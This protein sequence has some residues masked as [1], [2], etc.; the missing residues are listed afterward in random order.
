MDEALL[1]N[2]TP[3]VLGILMQPVL[4]E[5]LRVWR[6][7][8]RG[9]RRAGWSP[10]P[11]A[12]CS[13]R[14]R[15]DAPRRREGLA[16]EGSAPGPAPAADDT[17]ALYFLCAHPAADAVARGRA[18]A[19]HRGRADHPPDRPGLPG[20]RGDHGAAAPGQASQGGIGE[21]RSG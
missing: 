14:P 18:H 8:R 2:L 1:R 13:T 7:T 17:L 16:D 5:A 11:G 21:P 6:P 4:V 10:W 15:A 20:A 3:K 12:G 9:I 19:A